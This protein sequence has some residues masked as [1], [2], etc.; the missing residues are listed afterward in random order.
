M[1]LEDAKLNSR[2]FLNPWEQ[3]KTPFRKAVWKTGNGNVE[4]NQLRLC[5]N[6]PR[7]LATHFFSVEVL[8][9]PSQSIFSAWKSSATSREPFFQRGNP[10]RP[11]AGHF[12]QRGSPRRPLA[13]RFFSVG[14]LGDPSRRVFSVLE[15]S[16]TPRDAFFQRW[17]ARRPLAERF[18]SV[19]TLR[20]PSRNPFGLQNPLRFAQNRPITNN[21]R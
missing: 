2:G 16:A 5:G 21:K 12:F 14:M 4:P 8:R 15:S 17:N 11:L 13:E 7:P 18:F 3:W 19:E 1:R 9:G 10:R 20:D 6:P